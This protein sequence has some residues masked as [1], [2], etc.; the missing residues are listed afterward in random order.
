MYQR[1]ERTVVEKKGTDFQY[2]LF[3]QYVVYESK[4]HT[5]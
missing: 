2:T 4:T 5:Q 1:Q 3:E